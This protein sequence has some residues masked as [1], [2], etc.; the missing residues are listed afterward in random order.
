MDQGVKLLEK[1]TDRKIIMKKYII[2]H[3]YTVEADSTEEAVLVLDNKHLEEY[4]ERV[5]SGKTTV[6]ELK[7]Q[8]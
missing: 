5:R 3:A 6:K 2:T 7:G 1:K 4:R 8:Q